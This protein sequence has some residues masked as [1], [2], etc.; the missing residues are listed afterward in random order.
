MSPPPPAPR[1]ARLGCR[2]HRGRSVAP[3][4]VLGRGA[5]GSPQRLRPLKCRPDAPERPLRGARP[6]GGGAASRR[7]VPCAPRRP[8]PLSR[9]PSPVSCPAL[10]RRDVGVEFSGD[11]ALGGRSG[12]RGSAV[13]GA[14]SRV[15][16]G[17]GPAPRGCLWRH[18]CPRGPGPLPFP[19]SRRCPGGKPRG[20]VGALGGRD[21]LGESVRKGDG[22]S[23]RERERES[24]KEERAAR[25]RDGGRRP[26]RERGSFVRAPR[27][28]TPNP[29]CLLRP[30]PLPV[31]PTPALSAPL[32]PA[33]DAPRT[34][35]RRRPAP[36]L[37]AR[38]APGRP[39]RRSGALLPWAV[40]PQAGRIGP[41]PGP[42]LSR[43]VARGGGGRPPPPAPPPSDCDLRSDVATR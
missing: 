26:G 3:L 34:R 9:G 25:A 19:G 31:V 2:R 27:I 39:P 28:G 33:H 21:S 24:G 8:H 43:G 23:E 30:P 32:S 38:L 10:A 13:G 41:P 22:K 16:R 40:L 11:V 15:P 17:D 42:K 36:P 14:G 4:P 6:V 7:P 18:G 12:Q 35:S 29:F 1:R 20:A 37:R 5:R